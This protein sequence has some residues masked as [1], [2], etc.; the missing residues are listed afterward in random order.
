MID[1]LQVVFSTLWLLGCAVILAAFSHTVWL[2][3]LRGTR[4]RQAVG[5]PAFQLPFYIGL[6]LVSLGLF[7]LAS[8]WLKHVVWAVFAVIFAWLSWS[9]WKNNH[10]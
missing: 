1:W 4:T 8:S 6:L 5:A 9:L 3:Q 2:A 7:F 10:A